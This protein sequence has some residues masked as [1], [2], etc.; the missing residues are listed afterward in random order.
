MAVKT[1]ELGL[2]STWI[3]LKK[4][5]TFPF[6]KSVF[7]SQLRKGTLGISWTKSSGRVKLSSTWKNLMKVKIM[8]N[9]NSPPQRRRGIVR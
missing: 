3:V 4:S 8:K 6:S 7:N 2:R 5:S 9:E 1:H